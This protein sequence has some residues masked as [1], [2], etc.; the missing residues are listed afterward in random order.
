MAERPHVREDALAQFD[1]PWSKATATRIARL[2][3]PRMQRRRALARA[4]TAASR[5]LGARE[6]RAGSGHPTSSMS[7]ADLAAVL[8]AKLPP[9]RLRRA[10]EPG[11]DQ[12]IFSKGHASPLVYALFKRRRGDHRRGVAHLPASSAAASRATRRRVL[13]WV[14]VATGSLGQGLPIGVGMAL[15]GEA[16][17]QAPVPRLG[18]L[19]RQRDG[20]G[21]H[22]GGRSS[23]PRSTSST[24]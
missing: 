17:R 3:Y 13:P 16:A 18:H 19:R 7:A 9:L 12:L 22:V 23:T 20:R 24:T 1:T 5:R 11:N 2:R 4:R 6:R 8:L 10:G 15:A 14:D 21:L